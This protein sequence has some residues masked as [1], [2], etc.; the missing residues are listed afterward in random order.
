MQG[1]RVLTVVYIY[2]TVSTPAMQGIPFL[3]VFRYLD[4]NFKKICF[5]YNK[6]SDFP[7]VCCTG[8]KVNAHKH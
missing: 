6:N 5:G 8:D 2:T 1:I 7:L 3:P 4:P